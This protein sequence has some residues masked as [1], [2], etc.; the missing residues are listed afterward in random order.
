MAFDIVRIK[1]ICSATETI[2]NA[3]IVI[4]KSLSNNLKVSNK[5]IRKPLIRLRASQTALCAPFLRLIPKN[6]IENVY[7]P[8]LLIIYEFG[9][10]Q[11]S[12]TFMS[13]PISQLS[14]ELILG[15]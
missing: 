13:G 7:L 10:I 6:S 14:L 12:N 5:Q 2:K 4:E 11:C 15:D 3:E 8:C 9:S 1:L